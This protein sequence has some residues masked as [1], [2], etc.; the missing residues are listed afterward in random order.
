MS[1][2]NM[3]FNSQMRNLG[4]LCSIACITAVAKRVHHITILRKVGPSLLCREVPNMRIVSFAVSS[5]L[6]SW[7]SGVTEKDYR[8]YIEFPY[9]FHWW[10]YAEG[11]LLGTWMIAVMGD[12]TQL[13]YLWFIEAGELSDKY[14][15]TVTFSLAHNHICPIGAFGWQCR[16]QYI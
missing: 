8:A 6:S 9:W 14:K 13:S 1:G 2:L 11:F 4:V 7:N 5:S 3:I 16:I 10:W 12:R 15:I